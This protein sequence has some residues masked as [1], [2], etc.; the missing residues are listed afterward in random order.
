LRRSAC[1]LATL[2][3][4]SSSASVVLG[5]STS[6]QE[7]DAFTSHVMH[8]NARR[9]GGLDGGGVAGDEVAGPFVGPPKVPAQN[10]T[11]SL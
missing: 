10:N 1:A 9:V 2:R 4:S 11:S 8:L 6:Y 5:M 3:A 7:S